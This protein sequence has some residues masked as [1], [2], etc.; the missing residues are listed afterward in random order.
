MGFTLLFLLLTLSGKPSAN[1]FT[2]SIPYE[3][4]TT[5]TDAGGINTC[6]N[7]NKYLPES[8]EQLITLVKQANQAG[9][10]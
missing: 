4:V 5:H 10:K 6:K 1:E 9:K 8:R 2:I 3:T 7:I